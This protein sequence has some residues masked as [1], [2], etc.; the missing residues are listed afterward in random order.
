MSVGVENKRDFVVKCSNWFIPRVLSLLL[1]ALQN[2]LIDQR[3]VERRESPFI[4]GQELS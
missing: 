1:S 2:E 4:F 3:L